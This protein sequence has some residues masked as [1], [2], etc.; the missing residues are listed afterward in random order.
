MRSTKRKIGEKKN[1][2]KSRR[3]Q[4]TPRNPQQHGDRDHLETARD[5][6]RVSLYSPA[7][8]DP[9]FVEIDFAQ[10][11]QSVKDDECYTYTDKTH[12]QTTD[13]QTN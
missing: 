6:P 1:T 3:A 8:I 11:S 2:K 7:S 13:R 12:I 4:N 10:L 9:G 5:V